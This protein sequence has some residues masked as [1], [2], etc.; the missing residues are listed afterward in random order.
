M[1][2][3]GEPDPAGFHE[4]ERRR[5]RRT[6]VVIALLV[7]GPFGVL[8]HTPE[9]ARRDAVQRWWDWYAKFM[10]E[11]RRP[12]P[13]SMGAVQQQPAVPLPPSTPEK[14]PEPAK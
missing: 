3:G 13:A 14:A 1:T 7:A 9:V 8:L 10:D 4:V 5:R 12:A 11:R 2:G 6:A